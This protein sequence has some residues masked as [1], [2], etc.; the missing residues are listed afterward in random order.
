VDGTSI[1]RGATLVD[2][3]KSHVRKVHVGIEVDP[4]VSLA[5]LVLRWIV[6]ERR[7]SFKRHEAY[8][9][10]KSAARVPSPASLDAPLE[11]LAE[12]HYIRAQDPQQKPGRGRPAATVWEVNPSVLRD[13]PENPVNPVKGGAAD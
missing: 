3:F 2:Y 13:H 4:R 7:T 9:D 10:L 8:S 5:R 1:L 11:L 12:L 6:R